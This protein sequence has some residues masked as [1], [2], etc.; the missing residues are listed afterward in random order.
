VLIPRI[1][2][3]G[4]AV[5]TSAALILESIMLYLVTRRRTGYHIFILRHAKD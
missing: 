2:I 5:S 4:A 1:G 3:E